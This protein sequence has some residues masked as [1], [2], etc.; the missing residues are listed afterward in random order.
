MQSCL[1]RELDLHSNLFMWLMQLEL[2]ASVREAIQMS[3]GDDFRVEINGTVVT[4]TDEVL[5]HSTRP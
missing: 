2:A 5:L 4:D 1:N 3:T